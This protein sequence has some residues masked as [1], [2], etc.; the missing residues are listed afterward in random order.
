M[1]NQNIEQLL[2]QAVDQSMAQ[3]QESRELADDVSG[4]IG[5]IRSEVA[6]AVQR[7]DEA[8]GRVDV[9]IPTAINDEM[10]QHLYIDPTNGDDSNLGG[11]QANAFKT[12]K[13]LIDSTPVGAT[14]VIRGNN[15]LVIDVNDR[16]NITNKYI[17][18]RLAHC[19][20]NLNER[21][22][23]YGGLIKNC[24]SWKQLNQTVAFGIYH[25]AA[26]IYFPVSE[27]NPIGDA[28]AL[29]KQ[30]YTSGDVSQPGAHHSNVCFQGTVTDAAS[31]YY[32]F[33]PTYYKS[34][35]IVSAYALTLG[36]NVD[37]FDPVY[38]TVQVG[39]KAV[40]LVGA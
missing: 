11:S 26:D 23:V 8:I 28:V 40:Y 9:A 22:Y 35:M 1:V 31:Q 14:V 25:Y 34:S 16:I 37:L 15:D 10:Y 6:Q 13:A 36:V 4:L 30:D 5:E 17:V 27:L 2:Q 12:L 24:Y 21:I 20:L 19:T 33:A 38:H 7:T 3:T 32:V 39:T 18:I 29:F